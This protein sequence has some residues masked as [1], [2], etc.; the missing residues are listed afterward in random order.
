METFKQL[1]G[2]LLLGTVVYLFSTMSEKYF[3]ATLTLLVALWFACWWIGRTPLTAGLGRRAIAWVGG[4]ATAGL[5]GWAAFTAL[6]PSA[7]ELPWRPY[8]PESLA[9]AQSQGKTVL[10]DFTA[11][12]CPTCKVN[13][14]TA[15]NTKLV[16]ELVEANRVV[17]LLADWTDRSETIKQALA[18][19]NSISIP[20]LAIYPAGRPDEVIVLPDLLVERQ[21][22]EALQRAGPSRPAA[23][24]SSAQRPM[25][26]K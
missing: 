4:S 6:V 15:I 26:R 3:L 20:L 14:K 5:V 16:K 13:S 24:Q 10:V 21:V 8:S 1:L 25:A 2:F 22:I 9:R 7:Y 23:G 17:P 19:L 12:W 11:N 18:E